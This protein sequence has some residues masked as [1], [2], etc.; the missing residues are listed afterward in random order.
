MPN[1]RPYG[2]DPHVELPSSGDEKA[3]AVLRPTKIGGKSFSELEAG[4]VGSDL[5]SLLRITE[6]LAP[7][8]YGPERPVALAEAFHGLVRGFD[9]EL[10]GRALFIA[11]PKA[12]PNG[13]K[14]KP[15]REQ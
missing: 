14:R 11:D 7:G 5:R 2:E 9:W 1:S 4:L 10:I 3:P 13:P 6:R 8:E 15:L 12:T